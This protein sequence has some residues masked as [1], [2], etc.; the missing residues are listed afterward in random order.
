MVPL[1]HAD[2]AD[3]SWNDLFDF[4]DPERPGKRGRDRDR[5]AEA[6]YLEITRKLVFFFAGRACQDADDLAADTVLRVARK[7]ATVTVSAPGDR[8]GYF[9]GVARNV[10]HEWLRDSAKLR[11]AGAD[12]TRLPAPDPEPE[13]E[14]EALHRCLDL[15]LTKLTPRARRLIVSYYNEERTA[16]IEN[17]RKLAGEFAKSVNA[18]RIEVHRIRKSLRQ[19]VFECAARG[20]PGARRTG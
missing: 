20:S 14:K 4:L 7:C 18:L 8:I 19:C 13:R 17:H 10:L 3:R 2:A 12:L 9:F 6:K 11:S 5:E 15:C 1:E 16:R